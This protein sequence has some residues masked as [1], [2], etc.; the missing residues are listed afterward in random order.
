MSIIDRV[1][2]FALPYTERNDHDST[3]WA[4][5][6]RVEDAEGAVG[7]GEAAT[8]F[9]PAARATV[10]VVEA[11]ATGLVGALAEPEATVA[12]VEAASW[13]YG[14]SGIARFALSALDIA[15]WDLSLHRRGQ[16]LAHAL[17]SAQSGL[18]ALLSLHATG[19]DLVEAAGQIAGSVAERQAVGVKVA[20]GKRGDAALGV[21]PQRDV[22]FARL[23]REALGPD[24]R[25]MIDVAATLRW[26]VDD[27]IWRIRRFEEH[28]VAWTE[29]PLGA[30]DPVGYRVLRDAVRSP[31]AYG[32]REWSPRGYERIARS[33]TLDV[34]GIDPGRVGGIT[35]MR[36]ATAAVEAAAVQGNAH[37]FA[38]P[39]L[40]ACAVPLSL[41]SGVF[42][43]LEVTPRRNTLFDLVDEAPAPVEGRFAASDR[44]G[45]GVE[46]DDAAVRRLAAGS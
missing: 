11:W 42:H 28:D 46:V 38:G 7:W 30:D 32:E 41:A 5:Y 22:D 21:D 12:V 17:P 44:P 33:G 14:D 19:A 6:V 16:A 27:A 13:W 18:P 23:L 2:A 43:Q 4:C 8:L 40:L 39:L 15:L 3:R 45:L 20:Y 9:E 29:E 34:A 36:A 31:I 25:L 35:G 24:A 10:A 37:A 26:S 1:E